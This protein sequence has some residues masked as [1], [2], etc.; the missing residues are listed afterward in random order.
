[1]LPKQLTCRV[2]QAKYPYYLLEEDR[3]ATST[4]YAQDSEPLHSIKGIFSSS[5]GID[6]TL[7]RPSI[8]PSCSLQ[9]LDPLKIVNLEATS[10]FD[11]A[12]PSAKMKN[13]LTEYLTKDPYTSSVASRRMKCSS[14]ERVQPE[15][16]SKFYKYSNVL[17]KTKQIVYILLIIV[18]Y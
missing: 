6:H 11:P 4:V 12:G 7:R 17:K 2:K 18:F 8:N 16:L 15:E 10:S 9:N 13:L 5:I 14:L 3:E 1:M